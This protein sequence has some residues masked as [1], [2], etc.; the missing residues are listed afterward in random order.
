MAFDGSIDL[1]AVRLPDSLKK[2]GSHAFDGIE[3]NMISWGQG[4]EEIGEGAFRY[5]RI[6]AELALPDSLRVIGNEAFCRASLRNVHIGSGIQKIGRDAFADT[7]LNYLELDVYDMIEVGEGAFA[8]TRLEDIDLPWDSGL[9]N[10]RA[11]QALIDSQAEGCKVWINN[12]IDCETPARGTD[13]YAE[14]ADG[15]L[16]LSAYTGEQPALVIWHTWDGV[17]ITGIGDA[18]FK[19]NQT[20][21]KYRVTHSDQFTAIGA[22][23]FA[24]SAVETV[25][26]YYTTET[27]GDYAFRDCLGL[28]EITLPA[29]LKSVGSGAFSGCVNLKYVTILCDPAI[30]PEDAFAGTA[31]GAAPASE[32]SQ[33]E[34]EAPAAVSSADEED[35][36]VPA[37][38]EQYMPMVGTWY[39]VWIDAG[40]G[41]FNPIKDKGYEMILTIYP[42]G[43]A[44]LSDDDRDP[45]LQSYNG[46]VMFG[47]QPL[48]LLEDGLFLHL[49]STGSGSMY[50]SR[51][52]GAEV[53][54]KYRHAMQDM[55]DEMLA[56]PAPQ[57]TAQHGTSSDGP[58]ELLMDVQ[59]L[60]VSYSAS[61]FTVD[62]S[63]LPE[64]AVT[65]HP[66][67]QCDFVMGGYAMPGVVW[68]DNGDG[69]LTI[70]YMGA[71]TYIA[72]LND[73]T[74]DIDMNGMIMHYEARQ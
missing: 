67:G 2:I 69:T 1:Q 8:N 73:G 65:L 61:G 25:D 35:T 34:P 62:A 58:G 45:Q 12:P 60:A 30:I 56:T 23:A 26:L 48:E 41:Q 52:R 32:I 6:G 17:Q 50:L 21:K 3:G 46:Y 59:Y 31:Y 9:E 11:W 5:V 55:I 70:D 68:Q 19:G 14:N 40:G 53:P 7:N 24:G 44:M 42:D 74:L 54:E 71:M 13:T 37:R 43:T 63:A 28:T 66:D 27:I 51:D 33:P 36:F 16:Y 47:A 29:S 22:E 18:V 10:Q 4:L 49:G 20:L 15:T 57:P 64:Y 39:G 72:V 38:E